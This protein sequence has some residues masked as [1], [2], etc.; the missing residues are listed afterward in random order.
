[1]S[2]TAGAALAAGRATLARAG[3]ETAGLD[4]ALLLGRLL[5]V[6]RARLLAHPEWPLTADH[7]AA[8][9]ALL[10]RRAA[11]EPLAY[12]TGEREFMGLTFAVDRRV[13][14]PRPET[15]L[16][17]EAALARPARLAVDVGVG[18]GAI[19]VSLAVARPEL[20]VIASDID[21]GALA[22]ARGNIARHGVGARVRLVRGALLDWLGAPIDLIAANLPYLRPDQ[23]NPSIAHEP[24]V[25]LYAGPDGFA[26]YRA[27]LTQAPARLRPGGRLLAEIDPAQAALAL[28][29]AA[30]AAPGW[31]AEVR[32]DYAGRPRLLTL[33]R[34]SDAHERPSAGHGKQRP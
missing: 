26:L 24:A 9:A 16:L 10:A 14:V 3:I 6:E 4:A 12:L 31:P 18:S 29:E 11:G 21:A 23:A 2:A 34:P 30:R 28:A 20:R 32:P 5:G 22:V 25:A 27:L 17:V 7:E 8:Y 33:T 19:A 13:L 1:V 15:E